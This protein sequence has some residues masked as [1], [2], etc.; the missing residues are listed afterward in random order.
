M[1]RNMATCMFAK[2]DATLDNKMHIQSLRKEEELITESFP[3]T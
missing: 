1:F 3:P 2:Y